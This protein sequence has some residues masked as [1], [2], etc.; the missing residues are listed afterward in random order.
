MSGRTG[1]TGE[2]GRSDLQ[3]MVDAINGSWDE[4]AL[5]LGLRVGVISRL[6]LDD[7]APRGAIAAEEDQGVFDWLCLRF[8]DLQ[9]KGAGGHPD[10][11]MSFCLVNDY[12]GDQD[13]PAD[14]EAPYGQ[15]ESYTARNRSSRERD[16]DGRSTVPG[17]HRR[18]IDSE[19][20]RFALALTCA[21]PPLLTPELQLPE[22]PEGDVDLAAATYPGVQFFAAASGADAQGVTRFEPAVSVGGLTISGQDAVD[23]ARTVLAAGG[24]PGQAIGAASAIKRNVAVPAGT[25]GFETSERGSRSTTTSAPPPE[26]ERNEEGDYTPG[27]PAGYVW[28]R[29]G[30]RV[31]LLGTLVTPEG[32]EGRYAT[33]SQGTPI[34]PLPLRHDAHVSMGPQL[35]GRIRF[36]PRVATRVPRGKTPFRGELWAAPELA[37]TNTQVGHE[38]TQWVPVV[39][40]DARIGPSRVIE[41]EK[42]LIRKKEKKKRPETGGGR[43]ETG[44]G[45]PDRPETGDTPPPGNPPEIPPVTE[46]AG[47]VTP[48]GGTPAPGG[49]GGGGG[50]PTGGGGP[51]T[52][53]GGAGD[54]AGGGEP[55]GGGVACGAGE[56][57]KGPRGGENPQTGPTTG[58]GATD[59]GGLP[60]V[61]APTSQQ[62]DYDNPQLAVPCPNTTAGVENK[63]CGKT[64]AEQIGGMVEDENGRMID[65]HGHAAVTTFVG[66]QVFYVF[67]GSQ[68]LTGAE[69]Q[70]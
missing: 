58:G 22:E 5:G 51:A 69:G 64:T 34:G 15:A 6:G 55:A 66:D 37:N 24:T 1:K 35:T 57:D 63:E 14:G 32:V 38:T 48:S 62:R 39:G 8:H 46:G 36:E 59:E 33:G 41:R 25:P 19:D 21:G 43:P 29:D 44:G 9:R 61:P 4:P 56:G 47:R 28:G 30:R 67:G 18:V 13:T 11:R 45:P 50:P 12:D 65:G 49:A 17:T 27:R 68:P 42:I 10:R 20:G 2:E 40:V 26:A 54:P 70:L 52:G 53:G 7:N 31:G 16:L 60:E 3:L 23:A